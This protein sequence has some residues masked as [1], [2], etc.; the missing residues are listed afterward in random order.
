M[1]AV[2]A[3]TLLTAALA[4]PSDAFLPSAK[5]R[6]RSSKLLHVR[7]LRGGSTIHEEGSENIAEIDRLLDRVTQTSASQ[8]IILQWKKNP[9]WLW[10]QVKGTVLEVTWEPLLFN[11]LAGLMLVVCVRRGIP[12]VGVEGAS[13][14]MFT[15]PSPDHSIVKRLLALNVMWNQVAASRLHTHVAATA[16]ADTLA[17]TLTAA[18]LAGTSLPLPLTTHA[19]WLCRRC[20]TELCRTH[21][22]VLRWQPS[23]RSRSHSSWG[24]RTIFVSKSPDRFPRLAPHHRLSP[25]TAGLKN[26]DLGRSIQGRFNDIHLLLSTHAA[27]DADVRTYSNWPGLRPRTDTPSPILSR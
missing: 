3:V 9:M 15:A 7:S 11:V 23:P 19:R 22:C 20:C 2:Q 5:L 21:I 26:M 27:R 6:L 1:R 25:I 17:D 24:T 12:A 13:W 18:A 16:L 4:R 14:P 8:P 10:Q